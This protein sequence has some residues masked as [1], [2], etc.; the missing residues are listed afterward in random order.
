MADTDP[1]EHTTESGPQKKSRHYTL[2][3]VAGAYLLYLVYE[4]IV[5]IQEGTISNLPMAIIS[6]VVFGAGGILL[7]LYA[8]RMTKKQ[9][10]AENAELEEIHRK[11]AEEKK[12]AAPDTQEEHHFLDDY[13]ASADTDLGTEAEQTDSHI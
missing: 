3:M 6:S 7:L 8:W 1:S 12:Q 5:D 2:Y 4:M 13:D 9:K 10:E 11:E